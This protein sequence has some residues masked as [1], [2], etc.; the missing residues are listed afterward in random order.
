MFDSGMKAW[1]LQMGHNCSP[2]T[3]VNTSLALVAAVIRELRKARPREIISA[4]AAALDVIH[5]N[6]KR[7]VKSVPSPA[8]PQACATAVDG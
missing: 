2:D 8:A 1:L 3:G 6:V 7:E 5:R 4:E